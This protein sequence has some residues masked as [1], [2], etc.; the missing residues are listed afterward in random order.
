MAARAMRGTVSRKSTTGSLKSCGDLMRWMP[1]G[2]GIHR[3]RSLLHIHLARA[4]AEGF[5]G[6]GVLDEDR[7]GD[8]QPPVGHPKPRHEVKRHARLQH[9]LVLGA[10]ADRALAPVW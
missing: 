10:Q 7:L 5:G 9:R 8:F 3:I 4:V 6:A 2:G 1:P